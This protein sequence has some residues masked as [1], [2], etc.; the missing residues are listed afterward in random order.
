MCLLVR[1]GKRR[2][3]IKKDE[4]T[5]E[6]EICADL[7]PID[8]HHMVWVLYGYQRINLWSLNIQIQIL[9][10]DLYTFP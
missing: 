2:E 10:T 1:S 7:L 3:R 5:Q 8:V 6:L 9:Q 4:M